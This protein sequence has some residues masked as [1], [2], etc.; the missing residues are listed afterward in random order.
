MAELSK[1]RA[2]EPVPRQQQLCE[3]SSLN[4]QMEFTITLSGARLRE[5]DPVPLAI[6]HIQEMLGL[7]SHRRPLFTILTELYINALDHGVL[8]LQSNLKQTAEGF[9]R[10]FSEREARLESLADGYI[11]IHI[12][13]SPSA[14]GGK[15]NIEVE[16]S[17]VG[18]DFNQFAQK[19]PSQETLLSGRGLS[20]VTGLCESVEFISPGNR[21]KAV[22]AWRNE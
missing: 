21:V 4:D 13:A 18:F 6:N 9:T 12:S 19:I 3:E 16:D 8:R 20:L 17:G 5:T 1:G 11:K 2:A 22:F 15:M 10:Y 7:H 14:N